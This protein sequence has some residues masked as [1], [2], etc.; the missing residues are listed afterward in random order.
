MEFLETGL[1]L[2]FSVAALGALSKKLSFPLPIL[3]MAGGILLSFVPGFRNIQIDPP[4]FFALFIPPLLF[5]D[6]WLIPKRDFAR[7]MRPV[8][9]LALGL[10]TLTVFAVGYL[11][12]YLIPGIPLAAALALGAVISPTDAV[13][14]SAIAEKLQMPGR[15][16]YIIKGESLIN[17]ASGLVAF[18]FAVA[19]VLTGTFSFQNTVLSFLVLSGGGVFIGL[20]VAWVIGAVR[21]WLVGGK[22]SEPAIETTLSLLTPFAAYFTAEYS[23]VS[24][25]LA[26]VSAGIYAG[27]H[28]T[29]NLTTETRLQTWEVWTMLL[30][31]FNGLVFLLLGL[32]LHK[33]MAGIIGYR[34]SKLLVYAVILF[35]TVTLIRIA[36]TF[37]GAYVP[38]WLF[39][40]I[41][42]REERPRLAHVFIVG[43]SGIRG[44]VTLAA[45]LSLP[46]FAGPGQPF[47]GRDLLV[48][49]ASSV[50][51]M[52]L[53]VQ[54]LTLPLFI[55]WLNIAGDG[56]AEREEHAARISVA[57]AAI[58]RI[59]QYTTP[60]SSPHEQSFAA[61]L[62]ALYE[63]KIQHLATEEG[64]REDIETQL[65]IERN[66]RFSALSAEREELFRLHKNKLIN[67][68][69][70]RTIQRE[71]DYLES[72]LVELTGSHS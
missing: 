49:L 47:P 26:V 37:P 41:R 3:Q 60:L 13:A 24:G 66:L 45:A 44:S 42:K 48:F 5:A 40:G 39:H 46:L 29:R 43:W 54:G 7:V 14:V 65:K 70:L 25:I 28:D 2:L 21:V 52:T 32:Q 50:I 8:L 36:W 57:R 19:A 51:V 6:G 18:K 20:A 72:G 61:Q 35:S 12:H 11:I 27:I 59:E 55:R 10:V 30:F 53:L 22:I 4:L 63:R 33:V 62:I 16:T 15:I 9:L 68:D 69:V 34:W 1:A 31:A 71:I 58:Q 67:E 23:H 56:I 38:R 64:D 17:D